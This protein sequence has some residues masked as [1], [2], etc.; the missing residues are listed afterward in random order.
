MASLLFVPFL[1]SVHLF[2]WD[3]INF[4]ECA[5]EMLV[6][7]NYTNLQMNYFPFWEK[8]PLFIWMQ[9]VSMKLFGVNEFAA[10]FPNALGGILTLLFLYHAGKRLRSAS[11]GKWWVLIYAGTILPQFYFHTGIIDPWFN[12]FIFAA[13]Y[14]FI[15]YLL[16]GQLN[17]RFIWFSALAGGLA[18]LTKGPVAIIV[19]GLALVLLQLRQPKKLLLPLS[20]LSMLVIGTALVGGTWFIV[21]LVR[22]QANIISEFVSYQY[23][24]FHAE[25]AGHGGPWSY[26]VV[27][28]LVG[29]FPASIIALTGLFQS[30][31][32]NTSERT[33]DVAMRILFWLV[34]ILFSIV[35]TKIIH[36]SSLCYF[37]LTFFAA[38]QI[39]TWINNKSLPNKVQLALQMVIA[40]VFLI[41]FAVLPLLA[42]FKDKIIASGLI[43]D[44][45]VVENLKANVNWHLYDFLP[46]VLMLFLVI[47]LLRIKK[48][49]VQKTYVS[50]FALMAVV[51]DLAVLLI[52]PRIE[53]YTQKAVIDFYKELKQKDCYAV[54]LNYLSYAPYFYGQKSAPNTLGLREITPWLLHG[55]IDKDVYF[56]SKVT[57]VENYSHEFPQLREIKR[58]NGFVF[59]I[60]SA[61]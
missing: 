22:G 49:G 14:F 28:L 33:M 41:V 56:V 8:P 53:G 42:E 43:K 31:A 38:R 59:Y 24:L 57:D 3:E 44:V 12:L 58:S 17:L 19:L 7:G 10:R 61:H 23:H 11:F 52:A 40:V 60:R 51:I 39:E 55:Q 45:M 30:P 21:L 9:A 46:A 2:D 54:S 47:R 37:P 35:Q 26:H 32:G 15:R 27:V 16:S 34:L 48:T 13:Y 25:D 36:Y 50:V 20:H 4:A 29:C 18:I 5:R 1:G 6:T